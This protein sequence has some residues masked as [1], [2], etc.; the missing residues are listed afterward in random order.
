[1]NIGVTN[2]PV[3]PEPTVA[4][5]ATSVMVITLGRDAEGYYAATS[6]DISETRRTGHRAVD[7]VLEQSIGAL[8]GELLVRGRVT[9][10]IAAA[11]SETRS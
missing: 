9:I 10:E 8:V 2:A 3:T 4:R 5:S 7:R 11:P 6:G 1:M